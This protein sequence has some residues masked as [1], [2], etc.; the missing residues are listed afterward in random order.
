[1]SAAYLTKEQVCLLNEKHGYFQ[2]RDAQG[3]VSRAFAQD[4][5]AMHE[6]MRAAAPTMYEYIAS[7]ASNG[8]AEAKRIL[9]ALGQESSHG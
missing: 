2:Y 6:R 3:D 8:C 5:I 1:M 4:A 7:S 9:A